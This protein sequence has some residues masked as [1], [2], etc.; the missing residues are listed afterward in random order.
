MRWTW[1]VLSHGYYH[2]L[3]FTFIQISVGTLVLFCF[4]VIQF[5]F[6]QIRSLLLTCP[7]HHSVIVIFKQL[8]NVL[9]TSILL[10]ASMFSL[11]SSF[12][13]WQN[14]SRASCPI[15]VHLARSN[16][17]RFK[18]VISPS[19]FKAVPSSDVFLKL[20][21]FTCFDIDDITDKTHREVNLQIQD[22]F[23]TCFKDS[24]V[25]YG[26]GGTINY[27]YTIIQCK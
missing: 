7:G 16:S 3:Q 6:V 4:S 20:R 22:W 18:P 12:W 13:C 27:C 5:I 14:S 8:D 25:L 26:E 23:Q 21:L 11:T 9:R 2:F 17:L 19:C 1:I 24:S 15:P 10:Q